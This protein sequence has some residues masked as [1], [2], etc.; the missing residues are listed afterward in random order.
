MRPFCEGSTIEALLGISPMQLALVWLV[1]AAASMLRAFTGFGFA[2]AAVPVYAFSLAPAQAVVL[3]VSLVLMVG[4]HT[5][6]VYARHMGIDRQWPLF[7]AA[8]PGTVLGA[9][10]LSRF[11]PDQFRLGIGLVTIVASLVLARFRPRP[12]APGRALQ[13]LTGAAGGIL[14]GAFAVP[15]PPLVV[16]VLASEPDPARS[17]ALMIGFFSFAGLLALANYAVVGYVTAGTLLLAV[18]AYPAMFVGDK[19]G[20]ALFNRFGGGHYRPVAVGTC[21]LIGVA[22]T[23]RS[24]F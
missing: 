11:D 9:A 8:V 17:R 14:G 5:L 12:R 21:L 20:F 1:T 7:V 6:P 10:M 13:L 15:G 19:A 22:I 23:L 18:S 24:L 3:C 16:Y 4:V 2:L